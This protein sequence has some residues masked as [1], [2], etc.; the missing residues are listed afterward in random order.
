[1]S[2]QAYSAYGTQVRVADGIPLA[3]LTITAASNTAPILITT[4]TPHGVV[5]VSYGT[6][7]GV[8]GNAGSNGSFVLEQVTT[9]QLRLRN[10]VGNGTYT[11]GGTL[12]KVGTFASIAELT[13]VQNAGSRT[14][15]IDVSSHDGNGYS[16]EIASL[17]RTNAITLSVNLVP[18]HATHD[19]VTG[20]LS[21]YNSSARRDWL[22]VLPPYPGTG[23]KATGHLYGSVTYYTMPLP[24]AG[25][26]TAEVELAFDGPFT[27]SS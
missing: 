27:W 2:T 16:S 12:T 17:K 1:M 14:D 19:E 11:S 8:V 3:A 25:A 13:N 26:V 18:D 23:R 24:V 6:I 22:L 20:L 21:L 7:T 9:T 15:M 4:S 5:D 10:S